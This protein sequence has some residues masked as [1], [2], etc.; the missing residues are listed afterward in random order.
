MYLEKLEEIKQNGD[1]FQ[2][3]NLVAELFGEIKN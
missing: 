2:F 1:G 3:E